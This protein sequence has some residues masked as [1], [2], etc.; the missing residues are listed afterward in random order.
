MQR[1]C[2]SEVVVGFMLVQQVTDAR[3]FF[4]EHA[5]VYQAVPQTPRGWYVASGYAAQR[6]D[7]L[8]SGT[9]PGYSTTESQQLDAAA[10]YF[11]ETYFGCRLHRCAAV[12]RLSVGRGLAVIWNRRP[13]L[14]DRIHRNPGFLI[15]RLDDIDQLDAV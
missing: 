5:G 9:S 13:D 3:W 1:L 11:L 7:D 4:Q 14:S 8:S 12:T 2:Q 15:R 6:S 10:L